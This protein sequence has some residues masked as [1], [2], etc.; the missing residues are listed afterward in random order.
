M[1]WSAAEGPDSRDGRFLVGGLG[2][3]HTPSP[4]AATAQG[5]QHSRC[6]RSGLERRPRCKG[7]RGFR[8]LKRARG[9]PYRPNVGE[10]KGP[11]AEATA[12]QVALAA[13]L[14]QGYE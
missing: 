6:P 12:A 13:T 10:K 5:L 7:A 14:P 8:S 2:A 4:V 9:P 11:P 1:P 3:T